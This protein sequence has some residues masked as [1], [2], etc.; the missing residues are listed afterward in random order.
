[1]FTNINN[2][3]KWVI[4]HLF[5][6][7]VVDI[8]DDNVVF[9][10]ENLSDLLCYPWLE[11]VELHFGHVH[12]R[13]TIF[14]DIHE[15]Q[16]SFWQWISHIFFKQQV[17]LYHIANKTLNHKVTIP[18]GLSNLQTSFASSVFSPCRWSGYL[19]LYLSPTLLR[20]L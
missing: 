4:S 7:L 2:N 12:L 15:Y 17:N 8:V 18:A 9:H 6:K 5:F 1:M 3:K 10:L 13:N 19:A 16:S 14:K 20:V 11:H